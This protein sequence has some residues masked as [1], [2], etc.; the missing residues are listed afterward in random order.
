MAFISTNVSI[1][2]ADTRTPQKFVFLPAA[3]TVQG[4]SLTFKDYFGNAS[5]S[6][7]RI[8]TTGLDRIEFTS[9]FIDMNQ[10]FETIEMLAAGPIN[11]SIVGNYMG[12]LTTR[13]RSTTIFGL[14]NL[15][16]W[17]DG[18]DSTT[19]L[20]ANARTADVV[21][22][23]DKSS[24][25][26]TFIPVNTNVRS[27]FSTNCI[28]MNQSTSHFISQSDIPGSQQ[29]DLFCVINDNSLRGP[30]QGILQNADLMWF[31]TD[32]RYHTQFFAD[33]NQTFSAVGGA[34]ISVRFFI[35]QGNLYYQSETNP[36]SIYLYSNGAFTL[37]STVTT[38]VNGRGAS[39]F[40]GRAYI[41]HQN[42][43]ASMLPNGLVSTTSWPA[44]NFF[45]AATY[46]NEIYSWS[47]TSNTNAAFPT[48][49]Y[50]PITGLSTLV[51][52]TNQNSARHFQYNGYLYSMND[53]G[54]GNFLQILNGGNVISPLP[55]W[56][57]VWNVNYT[58]S[59]NYIHFSN[60]IYYTQNNSGRLLEWRQDSGTLYVGL[61][62]NS[63]F[64]HNVLPFWSGL[65]N[66]RGRIGLFPGRWDNGAFTYCNSIWTGK[67]RSFSGSTDVNLL[68]NQGY[69][70]TG[71][72]SIVYDGTLFIN[73]D[74]GA[75]IFRYGN[76]ATV[77][78]NVS[79][80]VGGPKVVLLR[81]NR[82]TN[83]LWVNGTELS[84]K[85]VTFTY[86]NNQPQPWYV[87]G[88]A[89]SIIN[90]YSDPG[91]DHMTGGLYE[92]LNFTSTLTSSDREKVEGYLAW[93]YGIQANLPVSHPYFSSPP[94]S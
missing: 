82:T 61:N 42:G 83:S 2:L 60:C 90:F 11:W 19:M 57:A 92:I 14:Q 46:N 13:F 4:R 54:T 44:S 55:F 85:S 28:T 94:T 37:V 36:T 39:I 9:N 72:A 50:N 80:I 56:S 32:G 3:S 74:A 67:G 79:S 34:A 40:D 49:K 48:F 69:F 26:Y 29:E 35:L 87:G 51:A 76:G 24:N 89:G 68:T 27:L 65:V 6:T 20:F 59:V 17:L 84:N 31:E 93:K 64:V 71:R 52:F 86:T 5:F 8:S 33:G 38:I 77:D 53:S 41:A 43:L 62:S 22:W 66:Y 15:N 16:V 23:R 70:N 63:N 58:L 30:L 81:K 21:T 88:V 7:F 10:D 25:G 73:S 47:A 75:N 18:F 45:G 1:Y 78:V 91:T 12:G